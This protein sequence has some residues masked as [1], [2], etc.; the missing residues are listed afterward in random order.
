MPEAPEVG[1]K[2]QNGTG[3]LVKPFRCVPSRGH[4]SQRTRPLEPR[5][6]H[7]STPSQV[8][9]APCQHAS[10]FKQL[11]QGRTFKSGYQAGRKEG[12]KECVLTRPKEVSCFPQ[13]PGY[14]S[15]QNGRKPPRLCSCKVPGAN[16]LCALP[17]HSV[18]FL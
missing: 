8:P 11:C 6:Y 2:A 17:T 18:R 14:P 4:Q 9:S 7:F 1:A 3:M 12:K 13:L 5:R 15:H 10:L 16:A